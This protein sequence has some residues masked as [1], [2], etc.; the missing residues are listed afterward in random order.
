MVRI[1]LKKLGRKHRWFFRI[2]ATDSRMPRDGRA[3]EELGTYDPLVKDE[4]K[5]VVLKADR[6]RY[7]LSVG[8]QPTEKVQVLLDKY[9]PKY[10]S[11]TAS[12]SP[13]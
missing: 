11:P 4:E 10:A 7:W 1:R 2:V 6:V 8:A 13:S 3:I 12:A 9:L 5:K